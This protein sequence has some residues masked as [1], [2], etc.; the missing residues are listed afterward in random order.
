MAIERFWKNL[1]FAQRELEAAR[2]PVPGGESSRPFSLDLWL[3]PQTVE[4]FDPND[5]GFL[6]KDDRKGLEHAVERFRDVA[7][8]ANQEARPATPSEL[9]Q[10]ESAFREIADLIELNEHADEADYRIAKI[11][12]RALPV[13]QQGFRSRGREFEVVEARHRIEFDSDDEEAL[14]IW[15][16]VPDAKAESPSFFDECEEFRRGLEHLLRSYGLSY[17]PHIR[18]WT[19]SE[20]ADE[21]DDSE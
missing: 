6:S 18:F 2:V 7:T 10:A 20:Q 11:L 1:K 19:Q 16:I 9:D 8:R 13:L 5:F 17:W 3:I 15:I 12:E 14:W 21:E 4:G